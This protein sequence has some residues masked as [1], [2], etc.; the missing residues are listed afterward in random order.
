[1][2][3]AC[4]ADAVLIFGICMASFVGFS[5]GARVMAGIM[6]QYNKI[7]VYPWTSHIQPSGTRI[8]I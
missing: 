2:V 1:M 5:G 4:D 6:W 3:D 7:A 8:S